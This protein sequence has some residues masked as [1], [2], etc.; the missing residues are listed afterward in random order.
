LAIYLLRL[1]AIANNPSN[2]S[3]RNT[4]Q[5]VDEKKAEGENWKNKENQEKE[6][7]VI[8]ETAFR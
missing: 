6:I 8:F 2:S 7:K 4:R 5:Y 1:Y 3:L